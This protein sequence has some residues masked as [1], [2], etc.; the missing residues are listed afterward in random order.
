MKLVLVHF[1]DTGERRDFRVTAETC[2]LGRKPE[3]D[4]QIP[5]PTVSRE[6]CVLRTADGRV[7]VRDLG[8]SNGTF[9]NRDRVGAEEVELHAGDQL[10]VGYVPLVVQIDGAPAVIRPPTCRRATSDA[11]SATTAKTLPATVL[12]PKTAKAA[13]RASMHDSGLIADMLS[14]DNDGSSA[15]DL[16]LNLGDD[17]P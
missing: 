10:T 13:P 3:A 6:H 17:A 4:L 16:D 15:F 7:F 12:S 14:T 9:R 11:P 2:R 1:A 5:A 8:S